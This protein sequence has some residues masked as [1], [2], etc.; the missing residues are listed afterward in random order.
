MVYSYV[1]YFNRKPLEGWSLQYILKESGVYPSIDVIEKG[2]K[3]YRSASGSFRMALVAPYQHRLQSYRAILYFER[4]G[5]A[6]VGVVVGATDF[7]FY[8]VFVTGDG[9]LKIQKQPIGGTA[10]DLATSSEPV[11]LNDDYEYKIVVDVDYSPETNTLDVSAELKD[12]DTVL[13]DVGY[14]IPLESGMEPITGVVVFPPTGTYVVLKQFLVDY[15][16]PP[17]IPWSYITS[18]VFPDFDWIGAPKTAYFEH[19]D[20]KFYPWDED[21]KVWVTLRT[22]D[23]AGGAGKEVWL[24]RIDGDPRDLNNW[25]R[26]EKLLDR[27][28]LG[29]SVLEESILVKFKDGTEKLFIAGGAGTYY[30]YRLRRTEAGWEV[31]KQW[32][33]RYEPVGVTIDG[34]FVYKREGGASVAGTDEFYVSDDWGDTAQEIGEI[35]TNPRKASMKELRDG[36]V[37]IYSTKHESVNS[38][39]ENSTLRKAYFNRNWELQSEQELPVQYRVPHTIYRTITAYVDM[40]PWNGRYYICCEGYDIDHDTDDAINDQR[41]RHVIVHNEP[42]DEVYPAPPQPTVKTS[43]ALKATPI[44]ILMFN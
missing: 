38:V 21:G 14:C 31:E 40:I 39:A 11:T 35:L 42:Q 10:E 9:Y 13:A 15:D 5:S 24:Y 28:D 26:V 20:G 16:E 1:E 36:Y 32:D 44:Y 27:E 8:F 17:N 34:K 29:W 18:P 4:N 19:D 6:S 33:D 2:W 30:L 3:I 43:L 41:Q 25:I 12:G 22:H 7:N 23:E 37:L